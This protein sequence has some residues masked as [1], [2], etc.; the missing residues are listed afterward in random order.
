MDIVRFAA[1]SCEGFTVN[2]F[3]FEFE[4]IFVSLMLRMVNCEVLSKCIIFILVTYCVLMLMGPTINR[5]T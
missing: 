4:C 2:F 5:I 1:Q 3:K